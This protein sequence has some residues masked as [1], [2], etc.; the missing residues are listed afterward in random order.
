[1]QT[2]LPYPNFRQSFECLD[3]LRLGNQVWREAK[4]LLNGGWKHHPA[5]KMWRGY[6]DALAFYMLEGLR[7]LACRGQRYPHLA[8]PLR[9]YN[10]TN[11]DMPP[12]LGDEEFHRSHRSNL[13]RKDEAWYR[14]FW[15]TEPTDLP[16]VWPKS[17]RE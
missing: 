14:Q 8:E 5:S 2:F 13:L 1:M 9:K 11:P 16:Y 3:R 10:I 15:W 17:D 7:V 6:D 12:W 4:T